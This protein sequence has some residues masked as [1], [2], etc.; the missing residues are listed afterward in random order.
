ML[1]CNFPVVS[2]FRT[3]YLISRM[4]WIGLDWI[5]LFPMDK[6][7]WSLPYKGKTTHWTYV[8]QGTKLIR[9]R[10]SR[11]PHL[12]QF[13][14]CHVVTHASCIGKDDNI[15]R[16]FVKGITNEKKKKLETLLKN[17]IQIKEIW[18][19]RDCTGWLIEKCHAKG[20]KLLLLLTSQNNWEP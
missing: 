13:N 11:L 17:Y 3:I 1:K 6:C 12:Q 5:A 18:D 15:T 2:Y 9:R 20:H 7:N 19:W 4:D 14:I 8:T 10:W 16:S